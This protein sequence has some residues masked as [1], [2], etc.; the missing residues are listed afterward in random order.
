MVTPGGGAAASVRNVSCLTCRN[1]DRTEWCALASD[2]LQHLDRHKAVRRYRSGE[3]LYRQGD[4]CAGV[5]CVESGLVALRMTDVQGQSKI[6]RLAHA[7]Q[8]VGYTDF[9]AG[10]N[11]RADAECMEDTVACFVDG[12][13]LHHA[14]QANPALGLAFL[15]HA[16]A[17]LQR[18]DEANVQQAL[19]TVRVRLA[20]LL[21]SL[22]ERYAHVDEHGAIVL[23]LPMSWQDVAHLL[24]TRPETISRAV[25]S[26]AGEGVFSLEGHTLKIPDLDALLDEVE[27]AEG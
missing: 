24:G 22:K 13:T 20:H 21:L 26:M 2:E 12:K 4:G 9:F 3:L 23:A 27:Q 11:F 16:S 8:T 1:R 5:Y 7:G 25:Q 18:A 6:L 14:L 10:P 17:D 15:N 19:L